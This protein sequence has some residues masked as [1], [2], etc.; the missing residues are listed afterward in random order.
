MRKTILIVEALIVKSDQV[1]HNKLVE[2][3][4]M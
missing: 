3:Q 1:Y 4:P 2:E